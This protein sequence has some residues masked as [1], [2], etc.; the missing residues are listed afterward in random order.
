M[1]DLCIPTKYGLVLGMHL[2]DIIRAPKLVTDLGTWKSNQLMPKAA[3]P[4]HGRTKLVRKVHTWKVIKFNCLGSDFRLLIFYRTSR[5]MYYCWLG[6]DTNPMTL[7]AKYE[8]HATHP[9]WHLHACRDVKNA[10]KGRTSGHFVRV[11]SPNSHHRQQNFGILTNDDAHNLA[12]K[13]FRLYKKS[14]DDDL[15]S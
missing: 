12:V 13:K 8:Y 2:K 11:P 15:F 14:S 6:L 3:F 1:V 9:G 7:V 5:E 4:L 10:A